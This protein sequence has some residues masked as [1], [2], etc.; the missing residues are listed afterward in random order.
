MSPVSILLGTIDRQRTVMVTVDVQSELQV[1]KATGP[2]LEDPLLSVVFCIL[3]V[4]VS[5]EASS[6]PFGC[7]TY[8]RH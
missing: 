3:S 1:V 6:V 8:S 2:H 4:P 5:V 7:T